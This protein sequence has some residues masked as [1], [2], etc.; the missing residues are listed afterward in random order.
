MAD[1]TIALDEPSTVDKLLDTETLTV[2]VNT[3][4]RERVRIAGAGAADLAPVDGTAGLKVNLGADNDVTVTGTVAV[5]GASS[6]TL[7]VKVADS[8]AT[9]TMDAVNETVVFPM[10]NVG[11]PVIRF[12]G[13]WA[14]AATTILFEYD[15]GDGNWIP[16]QCFQFSNDST[17]VL[18]F[19]TGVAGSYAQR[20]DGYY[21][22]LAVSGVKQLRVRM[23]VRGGVDAVTATFYGNYAQP[24][25]IFASCYGDIMH[26]AAEE[27]NV[28]GAK[29]VCPPVKIGGRAFFTGTPSAN[30][31]L[32]TPVSATGD[33]C[34]LS[35]S[36]Y[37][38]ARVVQSDRHVDG[39]IT[40]N[41]QTVEIRC[42]GINALY[43]DI[44][45]T[46]TAT[47]N[48]EATADGI[49]YFT[50]LGYNMDI[51][52]GL[53][54]TLDYMLSRTGNG[55]WAVQMHSGV[56]AVRVRCSAYTSG[57]ITVDFHG[58]AA[59]SPIL[60]AFVSGD[61]AHDSSDRST[62]PNKI[63]GKAVTGGL[64][65]AVTN[66][67]RVNALFDVY[68]RQVIRQQDTWKV[69]HQPA[70]AT[71]ATISQAAAG[72]G[73]KNVCTSITCT[74]SS[75]AAPT[76]GRVVFNLRD[77]ASGAGTILWSG[78]LSLQAVAGVC[79][80][81]IQISGLWIEGTANTAMTL[82]SAA[83]PAANIFATVAMTGT[84]TQ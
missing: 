9:G 78:A 64:P 48:L 19:V 25:S 4:E 65:A 6:T 61:T 24:D 41:G 44:R 63:G 18:R 80:P 52:T 1:G 31:T 12:G 82:E 60:T 13:T 17:P 35:M 21:K 56:Y 51:T 36:P 27:Y 68:G 62:Y 49:N 14:N 71:Q 38:E 37:G 45:G 26:D 23:S 7:P 75:S 8:T 54:G 67:D 42:E 69:Q 15:C 81:P 10:E 66:A 30:T 73:I 39:T 76:A 83:A 5:D 20:T 50:V 16:M 79:A 40:G 53:T 55:T 3:V 47:W 29:V 32:P 84:I 11:I 58:S 34:E 70:A 2:G 74:L 33:R 72:A 22:P 46:Y 59:S 28:A 43:L 77:G 57:T